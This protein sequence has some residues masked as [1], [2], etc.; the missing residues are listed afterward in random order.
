MLTSTARKF[1]FVGHNVKGDAT[2][3]QKDFGITI[4]VDKLGDTLRLSLIVLGPPLAWDPRS[5]WTLA[6][7]VSHLFN[8][9]L[10]KDTEERLSAWESVPL[11]D[12]QIVYAGLDAMA[13][14]CTYDILRYLL[15]Q[16]AAP[17]TK[18]QWNAVVP[19]E[20]GRRKMSASL[21]T[22]VAVLEQEVTCVGILLNRG[23]TTLARVLEDEAAGA[24]NMLVFPFS[25]DYTNAMNLVKVDQDGEHVSCFRDA[26]KWRPAH[27][28]VPE[29]KL[30]A[31]LNQDDQ[32]K[33]KNNRATITRAL[34]VAHS[35][36]WFDKNASL[37]EGPEDGE[38]TKE[39]KKRRAKLVKK[40]KADVKDWTNGPFPQH[41]RAVGELMLEVCAYILCFILCVDL[42][43][44]WCLACYVL[45][46]LQV[47]QVQ[48]AA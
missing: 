18:L 26:S 10:S 30:P 5:S 15:E 40:M 23:N 31:M 12:N 35:M 43:P 36:M 19:G 11:A 32:H 39:Y 13:S 28:I 37:F 34:C 42:P 48:Y 3:L 20:V 21:G 16:K 1:L 33:N 6:S 29:C 7:L 46:V 14:I 24:G 25:L 2:R 27:T 41:E 45:C 47:V 8:V 17:T 44:Q 9:Q 38:E 22:R 4:P